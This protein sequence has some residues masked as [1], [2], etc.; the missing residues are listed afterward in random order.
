MNPVPTT[1]LPE[2]VSPEWFAKALQDLRD[3]A[4]FA[5][6]DDA[7]TEHFTPEAEQYMLLAIGALEQA[8]RF[9]QL[10]DYRLAR[11]E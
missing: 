9:A 8:Q 3:K 4:L 1:T 11:R 10:A 7:P 6:P 5:D 2:M